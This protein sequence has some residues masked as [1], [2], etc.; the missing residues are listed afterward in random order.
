M[1]PRT[2]S[3]LAVETLKKI[4]WSIKNLQTHINQKCVSIFEVSELKSLLSRLVKYCPTEFNLGS[5]DVIKG[6]L[7]CCEKYTRIPINAYWPT[8]SVNIIFK[9]NNIKAINLLNKLNSEEN[10]F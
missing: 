3:P 2:V 4:D 5:S 8:K 6:L 9:N 10:I 7:T 1:K